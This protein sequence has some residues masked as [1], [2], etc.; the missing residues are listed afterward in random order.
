MGEFEMPDTN[1]WEAVEHWLKESEP[2]PQPPSIQEAM[3]RWGTGGFIAGAA[4]G[5]LFLLAIDA[6]EAIGGRARP[7]DS[8]FLLAFPFFMGFL[9]VPFAIAGMLVGLL[10][11][12]R[13]RRDLRAN[14]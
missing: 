13:R 12:L 14:R 5:F 10:V 7:I 8:K 4:G 9:A 6:G 3:G 1:R 11:G 2:P